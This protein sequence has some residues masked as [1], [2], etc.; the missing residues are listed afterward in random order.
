MKAAERRLTGLAYCAGHA[1]PMRIEFWAE[2][3]GLAAYKRADND[4]LQ[5]SKTNRLRLRAAKDTRT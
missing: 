2:R 1:Y 4:L 3:L 5:K